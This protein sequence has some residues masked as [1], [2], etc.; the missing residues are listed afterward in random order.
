M[1]D[2]Q[3]QHSSATHSKKPGPG[4][5]QKIGLELTDSE[6]LVRDMELLESANKYFGGL[7][8]AERSAL[9]LGGEVA[10]VESRGQHEAHES[11][12]NNVKTNA[13]AG[14]EWLWAGLSLLAFL[15]VVGWVLAGR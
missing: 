14:P 6:K 7:T 12:Q 10:A 13:G 4:L 1:K 3:A 11:E 8:D 15:G 2:N 5:S 9:G